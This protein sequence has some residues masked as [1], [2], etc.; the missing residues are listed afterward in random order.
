MESR[1][2]IED[3]TLYGDILTPSQG[4]VKAAHAMD[5]AL[6]QAAEEAESAPTV[7]ESGRS[8]PDWDQ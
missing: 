1:R 3:A 8:A 2:Q 4:P 7:W 5:W 6:E